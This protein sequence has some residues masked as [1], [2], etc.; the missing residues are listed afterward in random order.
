MRLMANLRHHIEQVPP[1]Q[2]FTAKT[3]LAH[4][5]RTTVDQTLSRLAR[6]NLITKVAR[7]TYVRPKHNALV[8]QVM[9]AAETVLKALATSTG[10]TIAV[11]GVEAARRV[12][13][14]TQVSMRPMF[15]TSGRSRSLEVAGQTV[16]L[17]HIPLRWLE[18]A[19][20]LVG[21]AIAAIHYLGKAQTTPE[22]FAAIGRSLGKEDF[23]TFKEALPSLPGWVSEHFY[24]YER[25]HE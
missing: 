12:Q 3:L 7:G 5:P 6:E 1:G 20:T 2:P 4:A 14:S 10:E 16:T 9:P 13:L 11:H 19:G 24:H 18:H 22:T 15:Y 25:S 23:I 17:E 21:D 8:G